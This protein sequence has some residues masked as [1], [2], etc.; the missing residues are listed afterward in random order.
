MSSSVINL[1][2]PK[3][4]T[5]AS[6]VLRRLGSFEH[7]FWLMDQHRPLHFGMV[8]QIRGKATPAQ[9]RQ[10]LA[11]VQSRHPL[12]SAFIESVPGGPPRFRQ[13]DSAPIPIRTKTGD[14]RS[15]WQRV[16]G[17]ELVNPFL[18]DQA[19][20]ARVVLIQGDNST[21]FILL[22]HHA[23]ADGAAAAY[24]VRDTLHA[25]AGQQLPPMPTEPSQD[26]IIGG[27]L[28]TTAHFNA[29]PEPTAPPAPAAP[30]AG[31]SMTFRPLDFAIP[32]VQGLRLPPIFTARLRSRA[33][34]ERTSVHAALCTALVVAGRQSHS[35][36]RDIP[37][38]VVSPIQTRT[39]LN[40]G[41]S[42]GCYLS[43]VSQSF[44][45]GT[46]YFWNLAR[47]TKAAISQA[48]NP[49]AIAAVNHAIELFLAGDPDPQQAA[50]FVATSFARE[51]MISN[52]GEV[53]FPS[54]YGSLTL[55]SLWG[56]SVLAG[57]EDEH[58]IGVATI[59]GTMCITHTSH[60]PP[61]GLLPTMQTILVKACFG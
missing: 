34:E 13:S 59:N 50:E 18:T 44:A 35:T 6:Q 20:L 1:E 58:F 14:P 57:Y 8:A 19:P 11:M 23:I 2:T 30:A 39:T 43:A 27:S 55:E 3:Q 60:T 29:P 17:E 48:R 7:L 9:W 21:A 42:C 46:S 49:Q 45:P 24:V 15:D 28:A 10:A 32:K 22:M 26:Q 12:L 31:P 37:I 41:E 36:W 54:R 56:P 16:L 4:D 52:L 61:A 51:V 47:E 40:I 5:I 33:H 38:R 53:P 25:L